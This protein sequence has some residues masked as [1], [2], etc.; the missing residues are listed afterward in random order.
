MSTGEG[1]HEEVLIA[2]FGGQGIIL[3]G[4][5]LAQTAIY[6]GKE[7]TYMPAYGAEVRGGTSNCGVIIAEY[8]IPCPV[9]NMPDS[10]IIMNKA[11]LAKFTPR[12]KEGGLLVMNSSLIDEKSSE[13]PK[14]IRV[15]GVP[16]DDLAAELG[17]T[18]VANMVILGAYLQRRQILSIE[19][20][21]ECLPTVLAKRHHGMLEI[22][23]KALR[24]G[25]EFSKL[26]VNNKS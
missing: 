2:G 23:A 17:N 15:L 16:A 12:L 19:Y 5:L 20:A 3:A 8:P 14:S 24:R 22:N 9:I 7:V 10:L 18:K 13:L 25:V 1:F 4:K 11:S 26:Y 6:D 21:I